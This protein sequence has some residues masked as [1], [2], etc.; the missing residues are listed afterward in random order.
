MFENYF[1]TSWRYIA[2]N[3]FSSII[4]MGGLAIGIGV[5]ILIGLWIW[6]E[7]SFDKY[8]KNYERI[9]QVMQHVTNNG[10]IQTAGVVPYPLAPELRK[11]YASDFASVVLATGVNEFILSQNEKTFTK[12]GLY[13]EPGFIGLFSLKILQGS[14]DALK[15]QS[16]ILLSESAAKTFFGTRD[17]INQIMKINSNQD[18]KVAGVFEDLPQNSTFYETSFI[19]TWDLFFAKTNWIRTAEDPWR[20][21]AFFVYTR[22]ADNVDVATASA[23]IKDEKLKNVNAQL[24]LKKPVLFLNPMSKWHL[25]SEFKN[26]VNTGGAI[27]YIWLFGIIGMFVLL[28]ACINFM[29]LSTARSEKRAREVGIR[30]TIGSGRGQLIFQFF[31]ESILVVAFSFVL[32]LVFVELMLPFFNQVASKKMTIPFDNPLFWLLGL[33]FTFIIGMIAGSYP[34]LYFS[35]FRPV[36]IIKGTLKAG[37]FS[38]VPRKTLVV[39]QFSVSVIMIIGTMIVFRQ[40]QFVKN[41]PIGYNNN[42]L[43]MI[44]TV[45][46]NI[47]KQF[48]T[49]KNE[50]TKQNVI[51]SI[52]ETGNPVTESWNS[53]SG[54]EWKGKDPSLSVDFLR[55][56][57]SHDYGK[58]V[59]WEILQGRDFSRD[60]PTDSMGLIINEAAV[61]FMGLKEPVGETI[62]WFDESYHVI[63][64]VKDM[65][66][67]NPYEEVK[68]TVYDLYETSQNYV[69][70]RINPAMPVGTALNHIESIFKKINPAQPFEYKFADEQYGKKFAAEERVGKLAGFFAGLAI[71]IS[72]L[73]LFGMASFTAERRTKEIGI[74]KVLGASVITIWQLLSREFVVLVIISLAIAIPLAYYF[75]HNWLQNYTYHTEISWWIFA[76]ASIVALLITLLTV[77]FQAIKVAIINP[78]KSLRT[79]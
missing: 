22:L 32:A 4:N 41:R 62:K 78:M 33:A 70:M 45:T 40:V 28:L 26:G 73:G 7:L 46:N 72:C 39:L 18:V 8:H 76:A 57:V 66:V 2:R 3:K 61:K 49:V 65:I 69:I 50:L 16:S 58:T 36:S 79:E 31:S 71:F 77:S 51:T 37:T 63:G 21:N 19:A 53:S 11:N 67:Q 10:Q 34:A 59:N 29:N 23:K 25:Q 54:F 27:K 17:P 12:K 64:V 15:D 47:H 38:A 44:P 5:S 20:P 43:V 35:S 14:S 13:A 9:A 30:K 1:K 6:D 52:A 55:T 75:M 42:E 68:P 48:N 60:Y 56:D 24:A 74:R